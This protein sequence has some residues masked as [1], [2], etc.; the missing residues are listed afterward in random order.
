MASRFSSLVFLSI[1]ALCQSLPGLSAIP[2]PLTDRDKLIKPRGGDDPFERPALRLTKVRVAVKNT[3][4]IKTDFPETM[5]MNN[6]QMDQ[7]LIKQAG[8]MSKSQIIHGVKNRTNTDIPCAE[9]EKEKTALH[10]HGYGRAMVLPVTSPD[11]KLRLLDIKGTGAANPQLGSHENGLATLEEGLREFAFESLVSRVFDKEHSLHPKNPIEHTI[12][13][14]A[15]LDPGFDVIL[16]SQAR[17]PAA[18]IVR[19]AHT[20]STEPH[21]F[22]K[23]KDALR[24]EKILRNYGITSVSSNLKKSVMNIQ[25]SK[26]G[27]VV[28]FGS[29]NVRDQ[30]NDEISLCGEKMLPLAIQDTFHGLGEGVRT[31]N[32]IF[33]AIR[34]QKET[35]A[36]LIPTVLRPG[37]P[38]YIS[39]P[40]LLKQIPVNLWGRLDENSPWVKGGRYPVGFDIS[41]IYFRWLADQF[42]NKKIS[43]EMIKEAMDNIITRADPLVYLM[44][45]KLE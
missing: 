26:Q 28:D 45:L 40:D 30:F 23:T 18:L 43:Q 5:D 31:V 16:N 4:L 22:L 25:G 21:S 14:Y 33:T 20:R 6:A 38:G 10:P 11:G 27:A 44:Q 35:Q 32:E 17:A 19:Q 8:Y 7:W 15:V 34:S 9:F 29:Y 1:W 24:I 36:A 2:N 13:T 42:N 37:D 39:T 3:Q 41:T 12:G